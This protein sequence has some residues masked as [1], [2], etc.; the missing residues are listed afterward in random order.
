MDRIEFIKAVDKLNERI[1]NHT[2]VDQLWENIE[3][4]IKRQLVK[5]Q[6]TNRKI[7]EKMVQ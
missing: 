3:N 6:D 2:G 1:K 4:S 7:I 5:H